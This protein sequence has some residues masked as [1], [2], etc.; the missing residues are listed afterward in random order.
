MAERR[1]IS[2]DLDATR[3][4]DTSVLQRDPYL[5]SSGRK[6]T[7]NIE[8]STLYHKWQTIKRSQSFPS[9]I[10]QTGIADET[11]SD[12]GVTIYG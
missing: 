4:N 5:F 11:D 12:P 10:Q 7:S 8:L 3:S 1:D 6:S 2:D 9:Q